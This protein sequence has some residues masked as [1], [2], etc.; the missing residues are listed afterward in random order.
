MKLYRVYMSN[1]VSTFV[2][3]KADSARDAEDL[4]LKRGV[5]GLMFPDHSY[6][7]EG[8][9]EVDEVDEVEGL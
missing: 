6:P 7:D 4:A 1:M 3:V 2:D 9:W 8:D 5:P